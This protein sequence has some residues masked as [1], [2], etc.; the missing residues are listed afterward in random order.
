MWDAFRQVGRR[1]PLKQRHRL[2]RCP[3]QLEASLPGCI[4]SS[5]SPYRGGENVAKP[6]EK[7]V[8]E[9]LASSGNKGPSLPRYRPPIASNDTHEES[10]TYRHAKTRAISHSTGAP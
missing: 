8:M 10:S 1:G 4:N 9:N 7:I 5:P 3:F 6:D 2:V